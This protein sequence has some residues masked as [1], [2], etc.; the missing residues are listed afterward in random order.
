MLHVIGGVGPGG[1]E[2]L[3]CRL[4][5]RPSDL[6]HEVVCLA[7]RDWYSNELERCGV[8]VHYLGMSRF[9]AVPGA[10]ARIFRLVGRSDADVVQGWMYRS[11]LLASL[12]ARRAGIPSVW[13]VHCASLEPLRAAARF[14]VYASGGLA[15]LLPAAVIN[16][17]KRSIRM[18]EKLGFHRAKVVWIPNGYDPTTFFPDPARR[19]MIR[20]SLGIPDQDFLIG[21]ISRWHPEKD[22]PNLLAALGH[23]AANA[24]RPTCLLIGH[25]LD[26]TNGSLSSAIRS[27]GGD[28]NV[29]PLGRRKDVTD[30]LRA[31]DLLVLPSRSESFPNV[32]PE[33]MLCQT[34]CVSTDV[35]DASLIIGATGWLVPPSDPPSIAGAI[36][37]ARDEFET[38]PAAWAHR[39]CAAR[40]RIER[41]FTLEKMAIAY[42]EIWKSVAPA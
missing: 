6:R 37:R 35:G 22:I 39:G 36:L 11:N 26:A 28:F 25:E 20:A 23:L 3:M 30:L 24:I 18:H 16:C 7:G 31:L 13:S 8:K 29:L 5:T 19:A 10:L 2:T 34:P 33:A 1:A 40:E 27:A 14:W 12:A 17:S 9:T 21:T 41:H 38:K 4:V 15:R 42:E 32:L